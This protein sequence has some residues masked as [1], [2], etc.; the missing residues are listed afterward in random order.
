MAMDAWY[1]AMILCYECHDGPRL[2]YV[3]G[4]VAYSLLIADNHAYIGA[5]GCGGVCSGEIGG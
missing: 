1:D 2:A 4:A 3:V 5:A